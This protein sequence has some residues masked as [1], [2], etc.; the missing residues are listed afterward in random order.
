MSRSEIR[1]YVEAF[2]IAVLLALFIITFIAQSFRVE[3]SSME[4]T[5]HDG[6]RLI[7]DKL[8]YR[9]STPKVGDVV[10]FRY[11]TDVTRMFIKRVI[12]IPGDEILIEDG[13]VYRNG[14]PLVENYINGPTHGAFTRNYGPVIVPPESYFVL[15]DNRLNSDDSR[16]PDVGFVPKALLVGRAVFAYWPL[17][18]VGTIRVPDSLK[19]E[20]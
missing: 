4:P 13:I 5:L 17:N 12:G 1:E 11:P 14:R 6:Q 19:Q 16:Y 7:V 8:S 15:G 2:V 20:R 10:V 9:F 3:G 18:T